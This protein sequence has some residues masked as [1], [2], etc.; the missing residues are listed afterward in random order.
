MELSKLGVGSLAFPISWC[1]C[2]WLALKIKTKASIRS[3]VKLAWPYKIRCCDLWF[4]Q[5]WSVMWPLQG[6]NHWKKNSRNGS[7]SC[8]LFPCQSLTNHW[9]VKKHRQRSNLSVRRLQHFF[10]TIRNQKYYVESAE[11]SLDL[12]SFYPPYSLPMDW[13]ESRTSF[14]ARILTYFEVIYA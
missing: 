14:Q 13:Q 7:R 3:F 4:W 2:V 12:L 6:L 5:K 9:R 1:N 11:W 10:W 8:E